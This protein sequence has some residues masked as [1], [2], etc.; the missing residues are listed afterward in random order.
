MHFQAPVHSSEKMKR[1]YHI[2]NLQQISNMYTQILYFSTFS[3]M[4]SLQG[5][6]IQY[7]PLLSLSNGLQCSVVKGVS[8]RADK[9]RNILYRSHLGWNVEFFLNNCQNL[10]RWQEVYQDAKTGATEEGWEYRRPLTCCD[11]CNQWV[12]FTWDD[13]MLHFFWNKRIMLSLICFWLRLFS[14]WEPLQLFNWVEY[15]RK[16]IFQ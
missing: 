7:D 2:N 15:S 16:I 3:W 13:E 11:S 5:A 12:T 1:I 9:N 8:V 6:V 10:F 14:G 4:T